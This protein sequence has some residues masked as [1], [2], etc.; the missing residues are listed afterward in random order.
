MCCLVWLF[1]CLLAFGTIPVISAYSQ[2]DDVVC[3]DENGRLSFSMRDNPAIHVAYKTIAWTL[4]KYDLPIDHPDNL[5]ITLWLQDESYLGDDGYMHT[6]IYVERQQILDKVAEVSADWLE[7]IRRIGGTAYLDNI[8]TVSVDGN[9]LGYVDVD[10]GYHGEVYDTYE[11]IAGA[12]DWKNPEDLRQYFGRRVALPADEAEYQPQG[13]VVSNVPLTAYYNYGAGGISIGRTGRL[14]SDTYDV[15]QAIPVMENVNAEGDFS[16]YAYKLDYRR[17]QG[18]RYYGV[19]VTVGV[20]L[21]WTDSLGVEH[22]RYVEYSDW[23]EVER[24]YSYYEVDSLDFYS[25]TGWQVDN[26]A[27]GSHWIANGVINVP[28]RTGAASITDPEYEGHLWYYAGTYEDV[29]DLDLQWLVEDE[30]GDIQ[31]TSDEIWVCDYSLSDGWQ[32][33][34]N[35]IFDQHGSRLPSCDSLVTLEGGNI[36]IRVDCANETCATDSICRYE[37]QEVAGIGEVPH[38]ATEP[39]CHEKNVLVNPITIHT[40]VVCDA[41]ITDNRADNQLV[42][43]REDRA[44]LVLGKEFSVNVDSRGTHAEFKGYGSRDYGCYVGEWQVRFPFQVQSGVDGQTVQAGTWVTLDGRGAGTFT[45]PV[46]VDEGDYAVEFRTIAVNTNDYLQVYDCQPYANLNPE[47]YAADDT[48]LVHVSGQLCEFQVTSSNDPA[49]TKK[50]EAGGV[51][52]GGLPVGLWHAGAFAGS[53]LRLGYEFTYGLT[54]VGNMAGDD[55]IRALV[56]AEYRAEGKPGVAVDLYRV[57][58]EDGEW[59]EIIPI[60]MELGS[61]DIICIG[62]SDDGH[63]THWQCTWGLPKLTIAVEK[64]L[65]REQI[66]E[67]SVLNM[68]EGVLVL[69]FDITSIVGGEE[70]LSYGNAGNRARGYCNMW[71]QEGFVRLG[72]GDGGWIKDYGDVVWYHGNRNYMEDYVVVGT[73]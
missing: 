2:E 34:G 43:P 27:I 24:D 33:G 4:K 56:S 60:D 28:V 59:A 42:V 46:T 55:S 37:R 51:G 3:F 6:T 23:Y 30:V 31:T 12:R 41:A 67:Q 21:E 8:M 7:E 25:L 62:S 64:G 11:G 15:W 69:N 73:H 5:T 48:V 32:M 36:P 52:A 65:D 50:L 26:A 47:Y 20:D 22:S 45:L 18:T 44:S 19:L 49:W 35:K 53:P 63:V 10:G 72:G 40:P 1:V 54:C 14:Y 70:H 66:D 38:S 13:E 39:S 9:P 71:Q 61:S 17:V 16:A 29:P 58:T 68:E 57:V